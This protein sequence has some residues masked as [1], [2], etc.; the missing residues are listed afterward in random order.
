MKTFNLKK[1]TI[2]SKDELSKSEKPEEK[3]PKKN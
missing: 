3:K 1:Q 2:T